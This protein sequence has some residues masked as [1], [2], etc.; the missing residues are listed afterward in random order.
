VAG[1]AVQ[2]VIEKAG[3]CPGGEDLPSWKR[4]VTVPALV[5]KSGKAV[6]VN[7]CGVEAFPHRFRRHFSHAWLD[8]GGA[9]GDLME[10]N[11]WA[12]PQMLR[13]YGAS[14]RSARAPRLR[15]DHG[16]H[17]LRQPWL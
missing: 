1:E 8:H 16:R 10:L 4:K 6:S 5:A 9:E 11:G 15:P 2:G 13:R 17:G 7:K 12:S 14:D 3:R